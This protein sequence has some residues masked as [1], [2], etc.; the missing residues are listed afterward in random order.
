MHAAGRLDDAD[1]VL[2]ECLIRAP[3]AENCLLIKAAVL[4]DQV[5]LADAQDMMVRFLKANPELS[6]AGRGNI[7][8]LEIP[9]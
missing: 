4:T 8:A 7:A 6:L 1:K 3:Q 2:D 5:K 9:S